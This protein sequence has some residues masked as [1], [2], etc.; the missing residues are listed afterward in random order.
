MLA[1]T[2]NWDTIKNAFTGVKDWIGERISDVVGFFTGLPG[3]ISSAASTMWDGIKNAFKGVI[4]TIIGWWN[5]LEFKLPGFDVGPIH[6]G[7]FTLGVPDIPYLAKGGIVTSPTLAMIGEAGPEAVVP[8]GRGGVGG[9]T[10]IVQGNVLDGRDLAD[11]VH[12]ALLDKQSRTG[13][14]AFR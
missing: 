9:I 10:I 4:N 2:K 1:I 13:S 5:G 8:L 12:S 6:V 11:V 3:R 14:L 7:G